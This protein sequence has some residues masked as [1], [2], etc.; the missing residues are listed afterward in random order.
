MSAV[1]GVIVVQLMLFSAYLFNLQF[2]SVNLLFA[3]LAGLWIAYV[4]YSLLDWKSEGFGIRTFFQRMEQRHPEIANRASL[5]VY[6][7]KNS[8]EIQR[9]GYSNELIQADDLWLEQHIESQSKHKKNA[10]PIFVILV[11]L[12][13]LIP[14]GLFYYLQ[15]DFV[16]QEIHRISQ[17][18]YFLRS[19]QNHDSIQAP[20][21][22]SAARGEPITLTAVWSNPDPA[23][24]PS[25][26]FRSRTSWNRQPVQRKGRQLLFH[27]PAVSREMEFYFTAGNVVSNKGRLTPIDPPSL[28]QGRMTFEPPAYTAMPE[29]SI[30]RLRPMAVP[31]G[32]R[33]SV[34]AKASVPLA[35]ASVFYG[36]FSREA[37]VDGDKINASLTIEESSDLFFQMEDEHGL[38]GSSRKYR[39]T[40][41]PDATPTL[42]ISQPKPVSN[43]PYDMQ[44]QVQ[45]HAHDDYR[46]ERL[47]KH[48]EINGEKTDKYTFMVWSN[49]DVNSASDLTTS[50]TTELFITYDWNLTE[51][52]LF[53][54]DEV[55]FSLEVFDNDALHG[56]KSFQ[57]QKYVVKY[58]SLVDLLAQ[59]DEFEEKQIDD[60]DDLVEQ[61]KQ[62]TEDAK[63]TIEKLSEKVKEREKSVGGEENDAW[64]EK[65]E[66]ES[67]QERQEQLIEEAKKIEE[68]LEQYEEQAQE[69]SQEEDMGFTPDMLEKIEK[70]RELMQQIMDEDSRSLM[71]KIEQTIDQMSQEITEEQLKDLQFSFDDFDQQLERTLSM[72]ENAFQARQ[73][74]S[75]KQ[76]AEEIAERQDH[77][78]RETDNLA[79]EKEK[80]ESGQ[81]AED[82][83]ELESKKEE[84]EADQRLLEK[85]QEQLEQDAQTLMDAMQDM[86]KSL[87]QTN[88]AIAQK[89]Q[90]MQQNAQQQ[91]LQKEMA[92]AAENM[93]SGNLKQA[94]QNQQ[95]TIDMLKAMAQQMQD[96]LFDM[97]GMDMQMDAQALARMI[98]QGLFL[99]SQMENLTES[100]LGR[101]EAL[102][103]LRRAQ[104][105]QRELIRIDAQWKEI[106]KTNPFMNREVETFLRA[107]Q[108]RLSRAVAA[109]QGEKWIGLH[110]TR[111]SMTAL[112]SAVYQMMQDMQN[113]QQQMSAS[114]S[115]SLQQQMQQMISQ[116]QSLQQM[117]QQMR[118]MGEKGEQMMEQLRQM[119]EQQ[120]KIRKE[121][122]RMMQQHRHSRQLRNQLDGIYQEMKEVEELLKQGANDEK[123]EEKQRRIMTRMLEA[124]TMQEEEEYG[125]E[126]EEEVAKT[127]LDAPP[128]ETTDP[129]SLPEKIDR[130]IERPDAESIPLPYRQA[131]KKYY[132]RLSEQA[133]Q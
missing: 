59:M 44:V 107:S 40:S 34:A 94:M 30:E 109:G 115:Q 101:S 25:V 22:V 17:A 89:L 88:P 102:D 74:E 130:F 16:T 129:V 48:V 122:E 133:V 73:L 45:L 19:P 12:A 6:A 127:G 90:E 131:L 106:S 95:N 42:E 82:Q 65:K 18:L 98:Q 93:K 132:I 29:Q 99:S 43:M 103:A 11:L 64:M 50:V 32:S 72:L 96:Q 20:R 57:S 3:A 58:P 92:Q 112:N 128:P 5:L 13:V 24:E 105:F 110:E 77:L 15:N 46:L 37:L 125:E 23:E 51:Y 10:A 114:Q 91:G 79:K 71:D 121:I 80:L 86:Q 70:I 27:V 84:L 38:S 123:V 39:F 14:S 66:L 124:G 69:A 61:Q 126:R 100:A 4:I 56:P 78:Q 111:G 68:Q 116:Q 9:L 2:R 21:N 97:Q 41:I 76:M 36:S 53:P 81:D 60:L 28:T 55:S 33:I 7:E 26:F 8:D 62:I 113:M 83:A 108:E 118:R 63:N 85:R 75:L 117:L 54:G 49:S 104:A 35:S 120:A 52:K 31:E 119:A 1:L 87:E 67:I 47:F